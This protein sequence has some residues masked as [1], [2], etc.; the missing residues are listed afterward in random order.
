[1]FRMG[2]VLYYNLGNCLELIVAMVSALATVGSAVIMYFT[3]RHQR[4]TYME[5]QFKTA[6]YSIQNYHRKLT[7]GLKLNVT[8][9]NGDLCLIPKT[10]IA[11]QCFLFAYN[12]VAKIVDV[13][14]QTTYLGILVDNDRQ[15]ISYWES[16]GEKYSEENDERKRC[17]EEI[18][19]AMLEY[20]CK[21]CISV[22]CISEEHY[23]RSRSLSDEEKAVFAFRIFLASKLI[24]YE[25]YIRNLQQLMGYVHN[26][27][28]NRLSKKDYLNSIAFQMAKEEL[29]FV[30]L[31]S[32]ID[33]AFKKYYSESEM[34]KI[35]N[36]QLTTN[37]LNLV[38][39]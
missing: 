36:E 27:I 13:L 14:S 26:E 2:D 12:E 35:V 37:T 29:W 25:H 1:M 15:R 28:P 32:Q 31:Y 20:R 7:D 4:K 6:F 8:M 34:D 33:D 39:L 18:E 17:D 22:Y 10:Y 16:E 38:K 9:L 11:R 19:K 3:F 24:C 5:V 30:K 23:K 21:Y